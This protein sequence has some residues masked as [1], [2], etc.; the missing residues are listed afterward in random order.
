LAIVVPAVATPESTRSPRI[1]VFTKTAGFRHSSI[2]TAVTAVRQL[3]E[4]NSLAVDAT[5]DAAAFTPSNLA[6]YDAVV[7]LMTTGDVLNNGQQRAFE[8]YFR[9]GGGFVGVHSAAD[10]EYDWTWYGS[11]L[12]TRFKNHP[13]IQR[14]AISVQ[15]RGHPSTHGLPRRWIRTDE[16]YNFAANPRRTVHA[17][18]TLDETTYAP[19]EGA[20][21]TD[22]PIVWSHE[23]QGG[24]AWFTGGGHTDKSYLERAFRKHLLGG[25]RYAAGLTPPKIVAVTSSVQGRR[26]QVSLRYTTCRPCAGELSVRARGRASRTPIRLNAGFGRARSAKLPRG[27]SQ[28]SVVLRDPLTGLEQSVRRPI[29]M[30]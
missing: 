20:M 2:P 10:T 9:R 17:L 1:L 14:A 11:M 25:I 16:W 18:A 13:Q 12:G 21:G 27:H 8:R 30:P 4:R 15:D 5:E 6:R 22:H 24:R 3:A 29:R 28:F 19:G 26:L 23:Y 7:F